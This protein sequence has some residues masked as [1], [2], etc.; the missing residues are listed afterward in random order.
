MLFALAFAYGLISRGKHVMQ[1]N[2]KKM[3][4]LRT[5]SGFLGLT[6]WFMAVSMIDLSLATVEPDHANFYHYS[7]GGYYWRKSW[8]PPDWRG[9]RRVYRGDDPLGSNAINSPWMGVVLAPHHFLR[10]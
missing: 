1:V 6:G 10:D 7:G 2:N 3:V 8:Y 5:L 9:D 4:A